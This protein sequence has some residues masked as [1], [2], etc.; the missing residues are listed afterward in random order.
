[1]VL[2]A[3]Q[4][5]VLPGLLT[6]HWLKITHCTWKRDRR[7]PLAPQLGVAVFMDRRWLGAEDTWDLKCSRKSR[8]T[9]P[10]PRG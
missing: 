8:R 1:M 2:T 6:E 3:L 9:Q 10:K 5:Q 4:N 7:K